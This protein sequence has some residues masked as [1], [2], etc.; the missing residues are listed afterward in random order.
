M[1]TLTKVY[2]KPALQLLFYLFAGS[3]LAQNEI[4]T[5]DTENSVIQWSASQV[6]AT[7]TGTIKLLEGTV[8]LVDGNI[9]AGRFVFDMQSI[10]NTDITSGDRKKQLEDHLRSEDFFDVA[11]HPF[12]VLEIMSADVSSQALPGE[13]VYQVTG[14]LT[15]KGVTRLI[16]FD[17]IVD[18]SSELATAKGEIIIDRTKYNIHYRS[19]KIFADLGDLMIYDDFVVSFNITTK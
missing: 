9:Q 5:V 16:T 3:V 4:K 2:K 14:D 19:G 17:T 8:K 7:H 18:L 10:E 13:T 6:T 1:K 12:A 11:Q 15:I